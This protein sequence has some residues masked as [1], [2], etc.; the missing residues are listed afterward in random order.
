MTN[1]VE[2]TY[3]AFVDILATLSLMGPTSEICLLALKLQG[4]LYKANLDIDTAEELIEA[5]EKALPII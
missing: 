5:F 3:E 4:E 2:K 1:D